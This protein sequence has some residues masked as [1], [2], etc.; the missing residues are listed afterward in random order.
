MRRSM[1]VAVLLLPALALAGVRRD[2]RAPEATLFSWSTNAV[3]ATSSTT[4]GHV[5]PG[6]RFALTGVSMHVMTAASGTGNF[7]LTMTDGTNTCVA[8]FACAGTAVTQVGGTGAKR[9]TP[10]DGAGTGC[11]YAPNAA[12]TVSVSSGCSVSN[13]GIRNINF[14]GVFR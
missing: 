3:P 13:P 14:L 8:T 11:V 2:T 12:L 10:A 5:L 1:L 4:G 9:V 7:V 6:S